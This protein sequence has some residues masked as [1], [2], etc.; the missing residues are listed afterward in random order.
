M[1][2]IDQRVFFEVSGVDSK[3]HGFVDLLTDRVLE[4]MGRE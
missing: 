3:R 1:K 2:N 4:Q